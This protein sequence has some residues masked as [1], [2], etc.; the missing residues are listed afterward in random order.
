MFNLGSSLK[1][2]NP[3]IDNLAV[4]GLLGVNNS[5]AYRIDDIEKHFHS[6]ETHIGKKGTQTATDWAEEASLTLFRAI[7]GSA[8]YGGDTGDEALVLGTDDGPFKTGMVKFDFHKL[9]IATLS[10]D[11]IFCV[12]I[13]WGT[14]IMDD[15]IT[16]KQYSH[17]IFTNNPAGSK[18]GGA[19]ITVMM[20]RLTY[21]TDK[22]WVQIKCA[23]DDAYMDFYAILHEYAG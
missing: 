22:I 14:G 12:R 1:N 10:T 20:P 5:L 16:A 21:G 7:S 6:P 19:P 3:K 23:T 17:I 2:V 4:D 18:A 13:I 15:A 9:F 11:D 8:D